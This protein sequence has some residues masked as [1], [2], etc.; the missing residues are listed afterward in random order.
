MNDFTGWLLD[1]FTDPQDGVVLWLLDEAGARRRLRQ[2]F[3]VTFYAA[4]PPEQLRCLWSYLASQPVP[5]R[6]AR[7]ER[8][9]LFQPQPLPVL[10]ATVEG[11]A[12][13]PALFQQASRRFPDL[14]YYDADLP[15]TL[16]YAAAQGVF[17]LARCR[18]SADGNGWIQDILPLESRWDLDPQPLPLRVLELTPDC[19]PFH[20][21]PGSLHALM[22]GADGDSQASYCLP[23]QP[24]RPLLVGLRAILQRHDPDLLLTAWGDTWLLPHL[25]ELSQ[26]L[27]LP[28]P[29]NREAGRDVAFKASQ[30]YFSY[31]QVIFRGQQVHLF[32]RFHIDRCNAMMFGDY[33]LEG[34]LE[35]ARITTL[36]LQ[37]A[38]RVSPGS[39]ISTM[40]MWVA[41]RRGVMVPWNK[42]QAERPKSA[43]DLIRADQGGMVYQPLTGLHRDVAEVDFVS[44]YPS[45]MERFNISPE[46]VGDHLPGA[47]PIPQL[48]C[49][50]DRSSRGLVPETLKPLLCKR[51]ALKTRL[52]ELPLWHPDRDL[53]KARA[54][55]Q[56]WLLVVCFGYLGYKNARF[57]RIEAHEA[58]TAY[59]R[60]LLLRAKEAS[61]DL[62][63]TALH[64]YVDGLWVQ[65]PGVSTV[66]GLQPLLEEIALQT[67]LPVALEGIY[68]WVAFLPSRVDARLPV[69]NRYFGV[70]QDGSLKMRGIE[71]RRRDTAPFIAAAQLEV[72]R[73]LAQ[74][75]T[76]DRLPAEVPGI[77]AF[78][79]RQLAD[80]R[81]GRV[82]LEDLVVGQKLSQELEEY[83]TPSPAAR[84]A[85]QL[86]RTGRPARPGQ[87]IRFLYTRGAPGVYAWDL[88]EAPNPATIDT[89]RYVT[90]LIRAA[91]TALQPLG[92]SEDTLRDWLFS[93][94]GK[95]A[96]PG[97]LPER[98]RMR[99]GA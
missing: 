78:L 36:P 61:E 64:L 60:E 66:E 75:S 63:Y 7:L 80:L 32:G 52:A 24:A 96:P 99:M 44:M 94:A 65:K 14:S 28:L 20:A 34:A 2:R 74:A 19:D 83:V 90:L 89:E 10:A 21:P 87:R 73:L 79:R 22:D 27:G 93:N 12:A 16:R 4:G 67:G 18:I 69:P 91:G 49:K 54:S 35:M 59:G 29:L 76:A 5:V 23:L 62:G 1:L 70:F 38:A 42:Q 72:L 3:P 51:I 81:T 8:Q 95:F 71:A 82:P 37:V 48:H 31:G 13:Q 86:E 77:L 58:V 53:Y 33:G 9:D 92:V 40:Q 47:E 45:I 56:K 85:A 17:P 6:L 98:A 15:I 97:V 68:R 43:M 41:L 84:A 39:G 11:A 57:G 46:T 26:D 25:M 30:S 55:A 88:P 50:V